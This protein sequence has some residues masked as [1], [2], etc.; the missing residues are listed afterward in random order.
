MMKIINEAK[1]GLEYQL[2]TNDAS[3]EKERVRAAE[4]E[5]SIP[6]DHNYDLESSNTSSKPALSFSKESTLPA[7]Q[8]NY[9]EETP[10][11]KTH[12][13]PWT[14]KKEVLDT[15]KKLH[16]ECGNEHYEYLYI[17]P[18]RWLYFHQ[19]EKFVRKFVK[20]YKMPTV[21]N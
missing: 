16:L 20:N 2:H 4:Y 9:N 14:S 15:I 19:F 5:I 3:R 1:D 6:S 17:L 12:P 13:L 11:K 21:R 8:T 10:L 7:E 18:S